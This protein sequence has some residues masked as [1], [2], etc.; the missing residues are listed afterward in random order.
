MFIAE[1]AYAQLG[2]AVENGHCVRFCQKVSTVPHT[3]RW[4]PGVKV[5]GGNV[6]KGAIIATFDP[7]TKRYENDIRGRSH[8]AVFLE[9]RED[10]LRVLD[11]WLG[12]PVLERTIRFKGGAQPHVDDGDSYY[13]VEEGH[14]FG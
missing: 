4:E 11:Q 5:R 13:V 3:S 14:G 2:K 8:A 9:E 1:N 7:D 12:R 6:P 10:G